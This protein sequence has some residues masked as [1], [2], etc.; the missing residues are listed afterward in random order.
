MLPVRLLNRYWGLRHGES[1]ANVAGIVL[2]DPA[3]G[4][5]GYGLTARG[6]E[7]VRRTVAAAD[8]SRPVRVITSDFARARQSADEAAALLEARVEVEAALRER[9]FGVWEGTPNT[10]YP[11]VW[12]QDAVDPTHTADGVESVVA[13]LE[14][15]LGLVRRLEEEAA[16]RGAGE[17][18]LLVSHGDTLQI[19]ETGLLGACPGSHRERVAWVNAE[20]RPLRL[21]PPLSGPPAARLV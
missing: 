14:R 15:A 7:Q 16:R 9:W 6:R 21:A 18:I 19:L 17:A 20:V 13:V 5:D 10:N 3:R 2:S 12:T 11:R 4:V 1:E 8:L